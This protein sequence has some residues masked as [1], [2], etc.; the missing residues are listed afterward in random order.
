MKVGSL[1]L[2]MG[3]DSK[4]VGRGSSKIEGVRSTKKISFSLTYVDG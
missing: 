3:W 2:V 4:S 1:V